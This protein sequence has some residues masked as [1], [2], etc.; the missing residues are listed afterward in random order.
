MDRGWWMRWRLLLNEMMSQED[1]TLMEHL[2]SY[3]LALVSNSGLT[4]E[5]FKSTQKSA[6]EN[7]EEITGELRP[8]AGRTKGERSGREKDQMS[9]DWKEFF[10]WDMNDPQQLESWR[11]EMKEL[12]EKGDAHADTTAMVGSSVDQHIEATKERIRQ[13]R[14]SAYGGS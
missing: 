3:H 13:R 5:S 6:R 7:F 11:K 14:A 10:G 1:R 8:W 9:E 4:E 12:M 2:Y